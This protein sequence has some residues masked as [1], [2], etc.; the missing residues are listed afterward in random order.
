MTLAEYIEAGRGTRKVIRIDTGLASTVIYQAVTNN[1][2]TLRSALLIE[3]A[4]QGTVKAETFVKDQRALKAL[5]YLRGCNE[6]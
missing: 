5:N 3:M 1:Y 6:A 2:A 4:T